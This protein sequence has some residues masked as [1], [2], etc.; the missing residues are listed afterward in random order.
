MLTTKNYKQFRVL[1][2]K[3]IC[4]K[5]FEG[6]SEAGKAFHG[7]SVT[8]SEKGCCLLSRVQHPPLVGLLELTSKVLHGFS[9]RGVPLRLFTPYD[10][11]YPPM[12]VGY[13]GTER[14]NII[15]VAVFENWDDD[16]FPRAGLQ[17]ILGNAGDIPVEL[18]A[19]RFQHSPWNW[20]SKY[21]ANFKRPNTFMGREVI[22]H[23]TINIDPEGCRDIDDVVSLW[24]E[25][26]LYRLAISI[27]DVAEYMRINPEMCSMAEKIGQTLYEDGYAVRP[28]FP[29]ELS[30]ELFS[31][32]P[33]NDRFALTLFATWN[34]KEI[35]GVEFKETIV[36]NTASYTYENCYSATEIPIGVL[37][38]IASFL[39]KEKTEDSH[40]WIE[41]LMLF[42]NTEAAKV[43]V[44]KGQGLL[45][46][47]AAPDLERL[48]TLERLGLPAKELAYPAAV[49]R[50]VSS[51]E[52]LEHWGLSRAAY[53]H[54]SSPI[55]RFADVLNQ[56]ILKGISGDRNY[57][58]L[59]KSL[60]ALGKGFER[61]RFFLLGLDGP[62]GLLDAI[63]IDAKKF[64]VPFWK[65]MVS[66]PNERTPGEKC[67][68]QYYVNMGARNWKRKIIVSNTNS[69][70]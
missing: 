46:A 54:A 39:L 50:S 21:M 6:A 58:L 14:I 60:T 5:E 67:V 53:C 56:E 42:Y 47:H 13:K 57:A 63:C 36:T 68:L 70:E 35:S 31:L 1:D 8:L 17:K 11:K 28:L 10:E 43:I 62:S 61:D 65:R 30:E 22:N 23:P 38:E 66:V 34:G 49:Y 37:A 18:E 29:R 16:G 59:E 19:I 51:T 41:A 12:L 44:K 9:R 64:Y 45:R 24:R 3:G 48:A 27:S 33:G 4:V 32:I 2:E 25:G 40:K 15:V 20:S 7:D 55:R 52:S 26:S 69:Q